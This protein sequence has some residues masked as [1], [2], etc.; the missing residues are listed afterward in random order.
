MTKRQKK[1]RKKKHSPTRSQVIRGED[2][3]VRDE[4][5]YIVKSARRGEAKVVTLGK[6]VFFST[7]EG[8]AW[9]LDPEDNLALRLAELREPLRYRIMETATTFAVEWNAQYALTERGFAVQDTD[10]KVTVFPTYPVQHIR[11]GERRTSRVG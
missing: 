5:R 2:L 1:Q 3:S 11:D 9:V 4:A 8:D 10:G 6:L 7:A